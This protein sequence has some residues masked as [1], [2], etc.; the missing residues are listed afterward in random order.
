MTFRLFSALTSILIVLPIL[1]YFAL[2]PEISDMNQATREQ[3]GGTYI[4]LS[5]GVTHYRYD[6]PQDGEIVVLVHGGTVPLWAWNEQILAL[7]AA[8]FRVLSYDKYGRGYSDRP[9]VVYDQELYQRQLLELV[10]RLGIVQPFDLIGVSLGG[11][12]AINFTSQYPDRV[13]KLILISPLINN[14]KVLPVLKLPI[15]GE[16]LTR[17][18]GIRVLVNRFNSLYENNPRFYE[19]SKLYEEQT[20]YKGFQ[21]SLLSMLRND[22]LRNYENAY[23]IVGKQKRNILLIWG[24]DDTEITEEMIHDIRSFVP[25]IKFISVDNA[26]HGILFQESEKVNDLILSFL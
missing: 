15:L 2:D 14:Y 23:N 18:I 22:A 3:L 1:I 16:F 13:Q 9:D 8:G 17:I 11:G 24:T 6:G 5:D 7:S 10:D 26:G 19:Y 25:H 12:T 20:I 4:S 21:G